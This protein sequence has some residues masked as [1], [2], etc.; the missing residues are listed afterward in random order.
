MLFPVAGALRGDAYT[1]DGVRYAM[2]KHGFSSGMD[3]QVEK[4]TADSRKLSAAAVLTAAARTAT[5]IRLHIRNS[6]S[7]RGWKRI[8]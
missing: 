2:P 5:G 3:W 6:V 8:L 7:V 4:Q 1:L